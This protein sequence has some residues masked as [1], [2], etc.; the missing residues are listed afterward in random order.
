MVREVL[1]LHQ[2]RLKENLHF[3][4]ECRGSQTMNQLSIDVFQNC[5]F[6]WAVC[7]EILLS[8]NVEV[9]K[10]NMYVL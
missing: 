9:S 8:D 7:Q 2:W 4:V 1:V 6:A 5:F 3:K 10:G